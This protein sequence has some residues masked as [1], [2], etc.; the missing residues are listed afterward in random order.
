[1][2]PPSFVDY[3]LIMLE[4][5]LFSNYNKKAF[6]THVQ[7]HMRVENAFVI[8]AFTDTDSSTSS[9]TRPEKVTLRIFLST[10][11]NPSCNQYFF[12]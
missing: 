9:A 8:Y 2:L 11:R 10:I 6:Y 3:Q 12:A 7:P 4:C 5:R 1:M